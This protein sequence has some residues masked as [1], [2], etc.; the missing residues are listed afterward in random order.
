MSSTAPAV[1]TLV[2]PAPPTHSAIA[3]CFLAGVC[4][5]LNMYCTQPLLPY[6]QRIFHASEI[7]VSLTVSS[8]ILAV[9]LVA[10]F[11]G[12]MAES[13]GRKNVIV[14]SLYALTVPTMLVAT[15]HTLKELIF[16]RFMQGIFVPGVVCVIMA[17]ICE[18]FAGAHVGKAMAA[19]VSGSV[20]G[21]FLGR[22]I[23]GIVA[24][25][26]RWEHAFI[27]IGFINLW[28][29]VVVQRALPK[30]KH[31]VRSTSVRNSLVE[32]LHHLHNPRLLAVYG[33]AFAVLF[34]LVG[35]FT[36]ANFHLALPPYH[37][38]SEDL[39]SVF[40]VYLLGVAITPLSGRFLDHYGM[41]RTAVLAFSLNVVGLLLTLMRPLPMIIAGLALFSSGV[42]IFQAVGTV[43]TGEVAG[44]ARSSAAGLYV[45]FYYIGG[46]LGAIV[47]GWAWAAAA[48]RGC[49]LL[50]LCVG[51]LALGLGF[52]SS[53]KMG[54]SAQ[55]SAI[56]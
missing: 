50:L 56:S 40:F 25:H 38:N 21:G 42:F 39:G 53:R 6:L 34:S 49:V 23:S 51:A 22:Y 54:V 28:G 7:D 48:W 10:P 11:V 35:A 12:L 14:P 46:S 16:W 26:F 24:Q 30:P 27:V 9:A 1:A 3:A 31:F 2:K 13:V 36:Y 55:P 41:R 18:E 4:T 47:T 37:L 33:M 32:M 17:Y 19:Y 43:Q 20:L 44:R 52:E 5:Y 15:S 45:T 29:A 8:T